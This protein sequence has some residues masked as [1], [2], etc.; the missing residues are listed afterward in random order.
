MRF[1]TV[2]TMGTKAL[3]GSSKISARNVKVAVTG[4]S[5]KITV[6]SV[7]VSVSKPTIEMVRKNLAASEAALSRVRSEIVKPG[8]KLNPAKGV[9]LYQVDPEN[10]DLLIR[11]LDGSFAKG[12]LV[13]GK[14]KV[15]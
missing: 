6:G 14:F 11:K 1:D 12:R 8:V 4:V 5:S 2:K 10:P 13:A 3:K 15:A 9:P 7:T